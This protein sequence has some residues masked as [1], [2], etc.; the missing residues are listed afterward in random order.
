MCFEQP[1]QLTPSNSPSLF[2][3]NFMFFFNPQNPSAYEWSPPLECVQPLRVVSLKN[4]DS[5]SPSTHQ[6]PIA[7]VRAG[8][9]GSPPSPLMGFLFV[10]C[11]ETASHY[12]V[13][14]DLELSV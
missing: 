10:L 4:A 8:T 7:L 3:I 1:T 9:G 5:P 11:F 13:L 2:P 14:A 6:L 12:L